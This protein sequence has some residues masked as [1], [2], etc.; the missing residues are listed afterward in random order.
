MYPGIYQDFLDAIGVLDLDRGL[1]LS[2]SCLMESNFYD[3][4]LLSTISPFIFLSMLVVTRLIARKRNN[5]SPRVVTEIDRKHLSALLIIA[6]LIYSTTSTTIFETFGCNPMDDGVD[7]L[8]AD[9][10]LECNSR[11]HGIYRGFAAV[12]IVVY[13]IGIPLFLGYWIFVNR[14]AL[15]ERSS[16]EAAQGHLAPFAELWEPYKP[17]RYYWE[18]VEFTRRMLLT[19]IGVFIYPNSAAQI[20]II[21]L[22][23]AFFGIVFEILDPYQESRDTQLYRA[24]YIVVLLSI[25]LALLLRVDVSEERSPSQDVFSIVLILVHCMMILAVVVEGVRFIGSKPGT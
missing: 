16:S 15:R 21:L 6:L 17:E 4:L 8:R 10:R 2:S 23:A 11:Q 13:P 22:L 3:Q 25:Y 24:G 18:I 7:Y 12:M 19:G 20:A 14:H 5:R 9:Y 1:I